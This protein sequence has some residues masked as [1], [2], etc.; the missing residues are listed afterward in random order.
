M[1]LETTGLDETK[2]IFGSFLFL[3]TTTQVGVSSSSNRIIRAKSAV[4]Y[5]L[6]WNTGYISPGFDIK[7]TG[8][9]S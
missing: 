7:F 3:P 5:A 4:T 8:P 6:L 1:L 2:A 9:K